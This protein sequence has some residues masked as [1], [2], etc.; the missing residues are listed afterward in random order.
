[1]RLSR[2]RRRWYC[3]TY[4]LAIGCPRDPMKAAFD[5]PL[6]GS[7]ARLLV[8]SDGKYRQMSWMVRGGVFKTGSVTRNMMAWAGHVPYVPW[9]LRGSGSTLVVPI[10]KQDSTSRSMRSCHPLR[11]HGT[12]IRGSEFTNDTYGT[13]LELSCRWICNIDHLGSFCLLSLD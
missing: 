12:P 1:M 3:T 8:R 4:I 5:L 11:M 9:S 13:F 10:S 7:L 2:K 6:P